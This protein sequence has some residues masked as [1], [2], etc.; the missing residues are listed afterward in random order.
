MKRKFIKKT[1]SVVL[2]ILLIFTLT[3]GISAHEIYY[4]SSG[5]PIVLK[6][7]NT[8]NDKYRMKINGDK[9]NNETTA[10]LYDCDY[11]SY[12]TQY[13]LAKTA[14][15]NCSQ[16][17]IS[18]GVSRPAEANVIIKTP[19]VE[20]WEIV[21]SYA[22]GRIV[23]GH[24]TLID[25]DG[26]E[27]LNLSDAVSS[28]RQ[29]AYATIRLNPDPSVFYNTT[30][31]RAVMVHELGHA[32]GLG[33]PNGDYNYTSAASVMRSNNSSYVTPQ[34]HDQNDVTVKYG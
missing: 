24:A 1:V 25:T 9:L 22:P 17:I 18:Q 16:V 7:I 34:S 21:E 5:S 19:S 23:F 32:L 26:N 30:H 33:H 4:T 29:I 6:W 13:D 15:H 11:S 2:S 14:W 10:Y 20:E 27:I 3:F 12:I 31:I 28:T 8:Y